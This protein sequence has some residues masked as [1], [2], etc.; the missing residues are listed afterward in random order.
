MVARKLHQYFCQFFGD[1]LHYTTPL[2]GN[3]LLTDVR[4]STDV[5]VK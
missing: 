4:L 5:S 3:R 1:A 2:H